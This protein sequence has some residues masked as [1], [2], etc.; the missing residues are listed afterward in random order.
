MKLYGEQIVARH[1]TDEGLRIVAGRLHQPLV[2]RLHIVAVHKIET[3]ILRDAIPQDML[4]M[5]DLVPAHVRY[6]EFVALSVLQAG[7]KSPDRPRKQPETRRVA[8]L[9]VFEKHLQ[10][11]AYPQKRRPFT[12][13]I[14]NHFVEPAGT[15]F[16]HAIG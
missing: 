12:D 9:A 15:Y 1:R 13:D 7:S 10:A 8:F 11:H 4:M 16:A 6:F 14:G 2:T 3:R 5:M